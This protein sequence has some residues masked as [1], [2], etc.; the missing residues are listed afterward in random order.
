MLYYG[1]M[2]AQKTNSKKFIMYCCFLRKSNNEV[3]LSFLSEKSWK[4]NRFSYVTYNP[5]YMLNGKSFSLINR[6]KAYNPRR[7]IG[8]SI[9][10]FNFM[11]IANYKN[12]SFGGKY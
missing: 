7:M 8:F 6:V 10:S 5:I 2:N 3:Y 11:A 12:R 1:K 4:N 9:G